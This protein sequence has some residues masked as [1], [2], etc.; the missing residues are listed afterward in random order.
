[1]GKNKCLE[2][3]IKWLTSLLGNELFMFYLVRICICL[4][5]CTREKGI[6]EKNE[7]HDKRVEGLKEKEKYEWETD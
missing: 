1:M 4:E 3:I 7:K 6:G 5:S 2:S